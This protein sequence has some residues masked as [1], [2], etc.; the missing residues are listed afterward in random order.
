M[1]KVTL[2]LV[3]AVLG[4]TSVNAQEKVT[5]Y[6][7][8]SIDVNGG[9]T[10]P[11]Q[12]FTDGYTTSTLES[13]FHVDLGVRYMVNNKF[14]L[15]ID[16]GY[17]DI[18]NAN[19]TKEFNSQYKRVSL[20]G[21]AN[22]G[23]IMN[24]ESW[25][26]VIGLQA[27]AGAGYSLLSPV[28]ASLG[29]QSSTDGIFE[30]EQMVHAIAGLTAQVKLGKRI[31]L[32]TDFSVIQNL[33]QNKTFDGAPYTG[34]AGGTLFNATLGLSFYL[35]GGSEHADWF[36][37]EADIEKRVVSLEERVTGI[38]T[39]MLDSD[40][41]GVADYLDQE[42]NTPAGS[43]VDVK[44]RSVDQNQ[45]GIPDSYEAYFAKNY[46]KGEALTSTDSNTAKS[47]INDGYVAVYFDFDKSSP[48]NTEATNFIFTYLKSN[49]NATIE[50]LGFA[51][52]VGNANY[53]NRLSQKRAQNVA[54]MLEKAGVS[55]SRIK[56]SAQGA[57]SSLNGANKNA[58]KFA[59]RV[60]FKVN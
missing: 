32:N 52:S 51:D 15:K 30:G 59:R 40:N 19:G 47:L 24:F 27:H 21:V 45:N 58:A 54:R 36:S 4:L 22:L 28:K 17:D 38:E 14:G 9:L 12:P 3:L 8:W 20:Q 34:K 13:L 55:S 53:N 18:K 6:N 26:R 57:D 49:P 42:P 23:R 11:V 35:G 44:G 31:A 33:N 60:T 2:P 5:D 48:K 29:N 43:I 7:K 37:Q 25:T 56:V 50:V 46:S 10:K 41:D 16:F 1:K 39:K